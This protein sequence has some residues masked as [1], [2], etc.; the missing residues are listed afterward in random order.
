MLLHL[1]YPGPNEIDCDARF[2]KGQEM[3]WFQHGSTLILF[4]PRGFRLSEG[5]ANGAR[6]RM[7]EALMRLPARD[8]GA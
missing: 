3:G 1:K 6:V 8:S 4:A 7:G 2:A 5:I